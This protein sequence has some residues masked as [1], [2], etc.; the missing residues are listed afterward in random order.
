MPRPL[1]SFREN[2]RRKGYEVFYVADLVDEFA[3]QQLK[4]CD[5]TKPKLTMKE[6]LEAD[7]AKAHTSSS[8]HAAAAQAREKGRKGQWGRDQELRKKEEKGS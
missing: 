4:E 1:R 6:D 8:K 5:G 3:V 7:I 2:L